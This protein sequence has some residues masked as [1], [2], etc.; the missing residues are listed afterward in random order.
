MVIL[1]NENPFIYSLYNKTYY[2]KWIK[3]GLRLPR[4]SEQRYPRQCYLMLKQIDE[5]GMITW[6]T[7]VKKWIYRYGFGIVWISENVGD[8]D[9]FINVFKQHLIDCVFQYCH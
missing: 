9:V 8:E 1:A 6:V 5:S 2:C 4:M 7:H 3:Y